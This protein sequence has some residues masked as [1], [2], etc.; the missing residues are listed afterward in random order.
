VD[1]FAQFESFAPT[2]WRR[3]RAIN[4]RGEMLLGPDEYGDGPGAMV[5]APP[6]VLLR[7]PAGGEPLTREGWRQARWRPDRDGHVLA[8]QARP[9]ALLEV[10]LGQVVEDLAQW[11]PEH[12]AWV[13]EVIERNMRVLLGHMRR[14]CREVFDK[15]FDR[16]FYELTELHCGADEAFARI[17]HRDDV[18]PRLTDGYFSHMRHAYLATLDQDDAAFEQAK[19]RS[20]HGP[21]NR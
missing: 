6:G 11:T 10:S 19:R 7:A 2:A 13:A 21:I 1:K 8:D 9:N 18:P 15:G 20:S 12:L 14:D 4:G 16:A 17:R 5:I 3:I